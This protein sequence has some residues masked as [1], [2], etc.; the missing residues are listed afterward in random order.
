[1]SNS[2]ENAPAA[3]VDPVSDHLVHFIGARAICKIGYPAS[4]R[5]AQLGYVNGKRMERF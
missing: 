2:C 3:R 4:D 1:M 5:I